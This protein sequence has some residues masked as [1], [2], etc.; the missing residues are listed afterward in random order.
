MLIGPHEDARLKG[1]P[2]WVTLSWL[3]WID[4]PASAEKRNKNHYGKNK[5]NSQNNYQLPEF[6]SLR[7]VFILHGNQNGF[8]RPD[9][10][11]NRYSKIKSYF[12]KSILIWIRCSRLKFCDKAP[13]NVNSISQLGL[14]HPFLFSQFFKL[15]GK[16]LIASFPQSILLKKHQ[17]KMLI[18]KNIC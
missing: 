11:R 14:S 10:F 7:K 12:F 3:N 13:W 8:I 6:N 2:L 18:I 5:R 9:Q 1:L 4:I 16:H 17:I 15:V